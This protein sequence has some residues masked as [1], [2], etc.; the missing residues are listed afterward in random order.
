MH[1]RARQIDRWAPIHLIWLAV[2]CAL[3]PH[4]SL[5]QAPYA[6]PFTLYLPQLQA[7]A[8]LLD[9]APAPGAVAQSLNVV[10]AW[11]TAEPGAAN[12]RYTVLLEAGDATP[13]VVAAADLAAT[14]LDP[15][16]LE[17]DTVYFWQVV[18][19]RANGVAAAGPVWH[20]RT[21]PWAD[22]PSVETMIT[23]PAGPFLMGCD[24]ANTGDAFVCA[25]KDTPLHRVWLDAYAIDKYEVTNGQYVACVEAGSCQWPRNGNSHERGDYLTNRAYS[26]YPVIY[27]SR[28]DGMRYC[29]WAGKRLP[30]EAEWEKAAR[31]PYDTRPLPWGDEYPDCTRMNRPTAQSCPDEPQDT[32]R[33]GLYG[34]GASPYGVHDLSGN[35]FEWVLDHYDEGYYRVSPERNP[36]NDSTRTDFYVIRG[37]SY[38]D[39]IAYTR[40]SHRHFGHHG[41]TVGGDSPF[42]RNDRVG[43]RCVQPLP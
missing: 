27:V 26:L 15:G 12:A 38:R 9:P 7:Q 40:V 20:F 16:T 32:A 11:R 17:L 35:V 37:G 30:T 22:N 24:A 25:G 36:L 14:D 2:L 4:A 34:R 21:E 28:E 1:R 33:V 13:D 42:Y 43:F 18:V 23:V 5:A 3:V 8:G 19:Q 31:G 6:G 41:D 39:R 10:L 29:A